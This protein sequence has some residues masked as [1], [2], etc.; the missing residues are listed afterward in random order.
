DHPVDQLA[1]LPVEPPVV[2]EERAQYLGKSEDHLAVGQQEQQILIAAA[3]RPP[4]A[5]PVHELPPV[6]KE[7]S[8][9]QFALEK[10][11]LGLLS[12]QFTFAGGDTALLEMTLAEGRES[13]PV[14]LDGVYRI[15]RQSPDAPPVAVRGAWLS[16]NEFG[17]TYNMFAEAQNMT[18]RAVFKDDGVSLQLKDPSNDL[19]MT[20]AGRTGE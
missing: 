9:K 7:I 12:I 10:N 5:Q 8:G 13:H 15:S 19:D 4:A 1:D 2:A 16:E 14:G 18:A 11:G 20:I 3:A 17:F 6:A